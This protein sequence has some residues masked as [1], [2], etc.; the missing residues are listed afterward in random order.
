M[1]TQFI[2]GRVVYAFIGLLSLLK[3]SLT[4]SNKSPPTKAAV[5][6]NTA[7]F[8]EH[9]YKAMQWCETMVVVMEV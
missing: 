1:Q 6:Y 7:I 5:E 9:I 4:K 3:K 8:S 2:W